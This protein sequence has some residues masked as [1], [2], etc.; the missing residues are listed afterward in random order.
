MNFDRRLI[1]RGCRENLALSSW[2]SRV[3][4]DELCE[5]TTES[6][7]TQRERRDVEQEHIFDFAAA[8]ARLNCGTHGNDF[9]R[10]D[11][12]V[13]FLAEQFAH[14]LLNLWNTR[15]AANE[16]DFIDVAGL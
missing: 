11:A 13:R 10:I 1:V 3:A 14:N 16:H 2:N 4:L 7:D 6:F 9:I 12:L 8:N 15:R 5:H